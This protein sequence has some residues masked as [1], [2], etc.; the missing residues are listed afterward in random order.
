MLEAQFEKIISGQKNYQSAN[1]GLN[2][3]ITRL[4]KK[5]ELNKTTDEMKSCIQEM[6]QFFQKYKKVVADDIEK[7]KA[8]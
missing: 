4:K 7:I 5:Y 8:L 6:N 2:L 1:L 3:L